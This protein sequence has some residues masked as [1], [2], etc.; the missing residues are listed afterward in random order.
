MLQV[1]K[2]SIIIPTYNRSR[3]LAEAID[4]ALN[5]TYS[6]V[7]VIVVDDGSTD[8]TPQLLERYGG[9]IRVVRQANG[10]CAS[11]RN[12]GI[13]SA[14]GEYLVFLD[15]DD[16]LMPEKLARE[17]AILNARPTH[18]YVFSD[19]YYFYGQRFGTL[20]LRPCPHRGKSGYLAANLFLNPGIDPSAVTYRRSCFPLETRFD[21]RLRCNEDTDLLIRVSL[22]NRAAFSSYPSTAMRWHATNKSGNTLALYA[23]WI[24]SQERLLRSYPALANQLDG[25]AARR[26][27]HLRLAYSLHLFATGQHGQA[28]EQLDR[29]ATSVPRARRIHRAATWLLQRSW[30]A[31]VLGIG[32]R[33]L[34]RNL[35]LR[36]IIRD[37]RNRWRAKRYLA[38]HA[39]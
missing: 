8:G 4:S 1:P 30:G 9:K 29:A 20:Y 38:T 37:W 39:A 19:S 7:E 32:A 14:G 33:L 23:D 31:R 21:E 28:L 25:R 26:M 10:G 36:Q 35:G 12:A 6:N 13:E 24:A 3:F 22:V 2:A 17:I 34:R 11:A 18:G 5:Q 16:R 27:A 15:S